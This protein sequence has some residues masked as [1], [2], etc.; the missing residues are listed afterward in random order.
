MKS[1]G[2][3]QAAL[4]VLYEAQEL[5][6][7]N[8]QG[9]SMR[10]SERTFRKKGR[11]FFFLGPLGGG[12]TRYDAWPGSVGQGFFFFGP[13]A[14]ARDMENFKKKRRTMGGICLKIPGKQCLQDEVMI[15]TRLS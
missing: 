10:V 9:L 6:Q 2:N 5:G 13:P 4:A 8:V 7:G 12:C 3:N 14:Q 15:W 1:I 11:V